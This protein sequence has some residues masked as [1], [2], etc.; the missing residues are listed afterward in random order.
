LL[1]RAFNWTLGLSVLSW[2]VLGLVNADP[3]DRLTPV[4]LTIGALNAVVGVLFVARAPLIRHGSVADVAV[5][6]PA[7]AIAGF[8]LKL[9]PPPH[10]WPVAAEMSFAAGAALALLS[11]VFLGRSFAILPAVRDVVVRGPYRLVRHPAYLG[12]LVMVISCFAA[13]P[14]HLGLL[15][16]A[17]AVPL[18]VLRIGAEERAL[19]SLPEYRAYAERVRWRLVPGVW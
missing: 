13:G 18:V 2:A 3:L 5:A 19:G 11:F 4:R 17:F 9:A 6:I 10:Q 14:T 12:E 8:A 15:P 7:V 16:L 1:E